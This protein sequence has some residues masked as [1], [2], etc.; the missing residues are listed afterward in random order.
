MTEPVTE[1]GT[2]PVTEPVTEP[3]EDPEDS[4]LAEVAA[5]LAALPTREALE[6][7]SQEEQAA[8]YEQIQ[9][10]YEA[11]DC[12]TQEQ[13]QQFPAAEEQFE[14][15]FSFFNQ[16][17]AAA[18][19]QEE[20]KCGENLTWKLSQDG[21]L[22]ISG[23]G[24][25]AEYDDDTPAPWGNQASKIKEIVI[26]DG[27]TSIGKSAFYGIFNSKIQI[28]TSVTSINMTVGNNNQCTYS[29]TMA[30]WRQIKFAYTSNYCYAPGAICTDGTILA[31]GYCGKFSSNP[32]TYYLDGDGCLHIEGTGDVKWMNG[33]SNQH[34]SGNKDQIVSVKISEGI[35]R[36]PD[37]AFN[38]LRKLKSITIPEGVLTAGG[39]QYTESLE[40][41]TLPASLIS[42]PSFMHSGLKKITIQNSEIQIPEDLYRNN[43]FTST[44]IKDVYF[45]GTEEQW[46]NIASTG[47]KKSLSHATMH[48]IPHSCTLEHH[49]KAEASCVKPGTI[50]YWYCAGCGKYYSDK[51]G[52][53][54]ISVGALAIPATGHKM[55]KTEAK[56]ATCTEAGN[57]EYYTCDNCHKVFKDQ[58]ATKPT[59]VDAEKI[60]LKKH[61]PVTVPGKAATCTESGLTD[62]EKCSVCNTVT[63]KQDVI[64]ATGHSLELHPAKAPTA[65]ESG[66]KA[67]YACKTCKAIFLDEQGKK[68]ATLE[69]VTLEA[70]P[71]RL[72]LKDTALAD[73]KEIWIG[74]IPY[75]VEKDS[76]G[77]PYV[78]LPE[79]KEE[80]IFTYTY[81]TSSGDRHSQ[82]PVGM[83]AYRLHTTAQGYQV[84]ALPELDNLLVYAGSSI[85]IVGKRGIRM[86]TGVDQQKRAKLTG[87]GLA[88]YTLLE[89]GT[90]LA[91]DEELNGAPLV[92][93]GANVR[94][95]Y[96]YRKGTAD[97]VFRY[98]GDSIQYT[99]VLV[100]F[101]DK[102]LNKD[103]AMRPYM[104]LQN[105]QGQTVV[106]YGGTVY[107]S[108]GFVAYQNRNAFKP[109]TASYGYV[110]GIIHKAYG[111]QFDA[112]FKG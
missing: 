110:W 20:N 4:A 32:P 63:K 8:A 66:N 6:Q 71:N 21:T 111:K 11:F 67:Y 9:L 49:E 101:Q 69:Q 72:P 19:A 77:D 80:L 64:K 107:R 42:I 43:P 36:F 10:A 95:N 28:P 3:S 96:A 108:I 68:P 106:V 37:N 86:I 15:L 59:T 24:P 55:T 54:A 70:V 84:E 62:G 2:E 18:A 13:Q 12:L 74:G 29:G 104:K 76:S 78:T 7:M 17:T 92:L 51:D 91:L 97:P 31:M 103:I 50:E 60:S 58:A 87:S 73:R 1:P 39:F 46:N 100:G 26:E 47:V 33:Q 56:E 75:P 102:H 16:Q 88:G 93:G 34:W 5:L 83:Q 85:R 81:N 27:V 65:T 53:T 109:G 30:Q 82:Y 14:Q 45:N 35:T 52:N 48:C 22:T 44:N 40:E 41:I 112:E 89:Y 38:G 23:N 99:N 105:A 94:S 25:M 61:T 79:A 57:N 90:L 98:A